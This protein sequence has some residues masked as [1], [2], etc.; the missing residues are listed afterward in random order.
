MA[1]VTPEEYQEKHAQRLKNAL[2][3]VRAGIERV[4]VNP[5]AKA[6]AQADKWVHGVT[7]SKNKWATNTAAVSLDQWKHAALT[8]GVDRISQG[9]DAAAGKVTAFA[10]KLLPAVDA[11]VAKI[12]GMPSTTLEDNI[13]RAS[14]YMREMAKFSN[15]A[16]R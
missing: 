13:A 3:E 10:A 6:A 4:T 11:A 2:P 8:K 15:T 5:M 14:T 7:Q 12:N 1:R 16:R 9:I